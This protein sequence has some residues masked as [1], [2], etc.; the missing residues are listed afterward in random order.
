MQPANNQ[1]QAIVTKIKNSNTFKNAPTSIALLQYLYD[2]TIKNVHLKEGVVDIE[3]FG[4]NEAS[5]KNNPRVRVN[6]Y[7]LRKK[8]TSYYNT[9]GKEDNWLLIID[10]GQYQVRFSKK[11]TYNILNEKI[12]WS[13]A[14]PYI[15]LFAAI[16]IIFYTNT[17]PTPPR[18]WKT[19]L[20]ENTATNL[21]IGDHFG[22]TGVTATGGIGWTRD[23]NINSINEFYDLMDEKPE[24]KDI[25]KPAN[26]SYST[27]MAALATQHFQQ[28]YQ[29]Y[30]KTFNIRFSTKSSISE[31]KESNA[32]YAGPTKNG[33]KFVHFFNEGNPYFK[34]SGSTLILSNHPKL[35]HREINIQNT[36]VNNEFAIV[37]K[38]PSIN[39]TEHFVFFSQ[40]DI[41]V[42]ATVEYFT[43]TDS[44][45]TFKNTFLK[46]SKYFTA[47]YKV[48][49]QDRTNTNLKLEMVVPF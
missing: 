32:I 33:N 14:F 6:V 16:I 17:A 13:R 41:G 11:Q 27:R 49:G 31:I 34:I 20:S 4:S 39:N 18:I 19:F 35:E 24:L 45:N 47:I 9:E 2:A 40:H 7:N 38:Y 1:K 42:S 30:N 29:E 8:L 15:A 36:T 44:L 12:N 25:L 23:F 28:F 43:N 48:K 26:Y 37:S 21:F 46:D 3:F 10:K 22:A 5:D